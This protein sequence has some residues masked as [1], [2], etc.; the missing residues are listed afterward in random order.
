MSDDAGVPELI[1]VV[2]VAQVRPTA[3]SQLDFQTE[4]QPDLHCL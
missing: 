1:H 2:N 4:L 3:H